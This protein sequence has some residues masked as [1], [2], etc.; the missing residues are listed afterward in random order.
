[1]T[2][3]TTPTTRPRRASEWT[4]RL[5]YTVAVL[6]VLDVLL[7]MPNAV[8][9]RVRSALSQTLFALAASLEHIPL[10][11]EG[12]DVGAVLSALALGALLLAPGLLLLRSSPRSR[13]GAVLLH[14]GAIPASLGLLA[15]LGWAAGLTPMGASL[16]LLAAP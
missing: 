15:G 14:L 1:M 6:T 10:L 4:D 11:S 13:P 9:A 3:P 2:P 12:S 16:L 7:G 8:G 5:V